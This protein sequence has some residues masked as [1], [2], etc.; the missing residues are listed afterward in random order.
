MN[1]DNFLT[2]LNRGK[3]V[4]GGSQ[5]HQMMHKLTQEALKV[6]VELNGH[7]YT[8]LRTSFLAWLATL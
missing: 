4:I 7:Y 1:I 3:S 6:T 5:T 8:L 2:Q